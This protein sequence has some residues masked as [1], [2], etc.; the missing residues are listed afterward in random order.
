MAD[1]KVIDS[2]RSAVSGLKHAI[3]TGNKEMEAKWQKRF[4]ELE[5]KYQRAQAAKPSGS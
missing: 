5:F 2:V 1:A 4:D 3:D